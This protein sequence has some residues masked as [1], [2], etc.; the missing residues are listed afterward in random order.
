MLCFHCTVNA[1][2]FLFFNGRTQGTGLCWDGTGIPAP[3]EPEHK[4]AALPV[5]SLTCVNTEIKYIYWLTQELWGSLELEN[6]P[7]V[8]LEGSQ[9]QDTWPVNKKVQL[10][11]KNHSR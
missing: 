10:V 4:A 1:F 5:Q 3:L 8:L 6:L 9:C 7:A 11:H 2:V